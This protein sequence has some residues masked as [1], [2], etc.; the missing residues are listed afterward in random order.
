[1]LSEKAVNVGLPDLLFQKILETNQDCNYHKHFDLHLTRASHKE[2]E[3]VVKIQDFHINPRDISHGAVAY[4]LLDTAMGMA[5]RTLN[6]NVVT[7]NSNINYTAVSGLGDTLRAVAQVVDFGK[8]I[9]ICDSQAY[10]QEGKLIAIA[11]G[12]FYDKGVFCEG[13]NDF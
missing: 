6:R 10:N 4:A 13:V 7:L 2:V 3:M 11:R 9:I 12:T 5:I 8:K 1:M